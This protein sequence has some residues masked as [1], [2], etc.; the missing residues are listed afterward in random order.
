MS[1][2]FRITTLLMELTSANEFGLTNEI[3][4]GESPL[5]LKP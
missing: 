5:N 2:D 3:I 1:V 4:T